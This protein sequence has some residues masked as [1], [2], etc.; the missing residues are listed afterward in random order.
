MLLSGS[1]LKILE[2]TALNSSF[3]INFTTQPMTSL[4]RPGITALISSSAADSK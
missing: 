2:P 3:V 1:G 4:D